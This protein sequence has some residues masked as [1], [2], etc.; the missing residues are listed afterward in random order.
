M[1]ILS[2]LLGIIAAV[3]IKTLIM[4]PLQGY[5]VRRMAGPLANNI[6]NMEMVTVAG[7]KNREVLFRFRPANG[8]K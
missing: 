5:V 8:R 4:M 7:K 6:K 3:L 1:D 2:F